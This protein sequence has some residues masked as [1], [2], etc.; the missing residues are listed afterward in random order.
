LNVDDAFRSYN[1]DNELNNDEFQFKEEGNFI[2]LLDRS[3]SMSG[4]RMN[5]A[6]DALLLFLKSLPANSFFNVVSFGSR[7]ECLLNESM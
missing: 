3:G 2:F 1:I 5:Q 6:K 4:S 7:Y